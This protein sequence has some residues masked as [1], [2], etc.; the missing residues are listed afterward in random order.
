[1]T[2]PTKRAIAEALL[3]RGSLFLHLDPRV[4]GVHVPPFLRGQP[5]VVLQVGLNMAIPIVDLRVDEDGVTATL[6]FN[7]T[8]HLCFVPWDA[9]F[10]LVGD[11]GR[12]RVFLESMPREIKREIDREVSDASAESLDDLYEEHD[13]DDESGT[14]SE[15]D[16]EPTS[17]EL[18]AMEL[19]DDESPEG[20]GN[21]I[22]LWPRS[23]KPAG[24]V[25][26]VG[27]VGAVGRPR[28]PTL[29]PPSPQALK[30]SGRASPQP[31]APKVPSPAPAPSRAPVNAPKESGSGSSSVGGDAPTPNSRPPRPPHPHLRRVK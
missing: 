25:A 29:P 17:A 1:M 9:V 7:R 19:P 24:P 11:D 12:G 5:Q 3:E 31:K 15:D 22:P 4:E 6:S 30:V 2:T 16:R 8:P 26:P 28:S 27:V 21:V 14:F 13:D 20:E 10:A 18:D 23:V